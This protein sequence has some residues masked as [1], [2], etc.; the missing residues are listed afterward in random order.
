MLS[1]K[2]W[3][4]S[5]L[6]PCASSARGKYWLIDLLVA[7][8]SVVQTFRDYVHASVNHHS[9]ECRYTHYVCT[10]VS[11]AHVYKQ[12]KQACSE[13][14]C[15]QQAQVD[16]VG[17]TVL[18]L[19]QLQWGMVVGAPSAACPIA[20]AA[21]SAALCRHPV[22]GNSGALPAA[23]AMGHAADG[24]TYLAPV[25]VEN[26]VAAAIFN[27]DRVSSCTLKRNIPLA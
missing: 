23:A 14:C 11:C 18:F 9:D 6:Q 25:I 15:R 5:E 2:S 8:T 4:Y 16:R 20:A 10:E 12:G 24:D 21:G 27:N 22:C 13:W 3:S 17:T 19:Q 7:V 1:N 26:G